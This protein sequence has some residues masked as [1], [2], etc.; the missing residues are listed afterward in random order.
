MGDGF[1]G[2]GD[3]SGGGG[4]ASGSWAPAA[5]RL[6]P[7]IPAAIKPPNTA[8][9]NPSQPAQSRRVPRTPRQVGVRD[10]TPTIPRDLVTVHAAAVA[11]QQRIAVPQIRIT[12]NGYE[13]RLDEKKRTVQVTGTLTQSQ[14]PARSRT[15]QARAGGKDRRHTD[16]GG[17]Y[18]AA[19]FNGPTDAFNH[20]AQ[21]ANF[22]RGG[23]KALENTW[24]T[25]L[26]QGK[27]VDVRIYPSFEGASMRPTTITVRYT[28]DGV[29][30]LRPFSNERRGQP[31][32]K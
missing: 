31:H 12:K 4:G 3:G 2:R 6:K 8:S 18:I 14:A 1:T 17:H 11:R 21:D 23:Y 24:A 19:R 25:A 7:P 16:D 30:R 28:I 32:G 15:T 10:I 26:K 20:F 9:T 22:N 27:H 13:F 29:S 5:K